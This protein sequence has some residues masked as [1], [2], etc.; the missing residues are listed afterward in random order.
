MRSLQSGS[1]D[2]AFLPNEVCVL[3]DFRLRLIALENASVPAGEYFNG[4][5]FSALS[6]ADADSPIYEN[7]VALSGDA[8]DALCDAFSVAL[9]MLCADVEGSAAMQRYGCASYLVSGDFGAL[10]APLIACLT[11]APQE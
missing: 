10:L 2:V 7:V 5:D 6:D 9:V 11:L 1:I 8:S 4:I 3:S